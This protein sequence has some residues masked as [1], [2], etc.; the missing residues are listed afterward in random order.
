MA[1]KSRTKRRSKHVRRIRNK[2]HKSHKYSKGKV[3]KNWAMKKMV[4]DP[5]RA[6]GPLL[7]RSA[8]K[9]GDAA[10]A[11]ALYM[12]H[13]LKEYGNDWWNQSAARGIVK[14]YDPK[15]AKILG[16]QKTIKKGKKAPVIKKVMETDVAVRKRL[17]VPS[18]IEARV[19]PN[20]VKSTYV[21]IK[22]A[23][24]DYLNIINRC[25]DYIFTYKA[26]ALTM[27]SEKVVF[28]IDQSSTP[29]R[30]TM[31]IR[32]ALNV[33][34][35]KLEKLRNPRFDQ[36][37]EKSHDIVKILLEKSIELRGGLIEEPVIISWLAS[38]P[39]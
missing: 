22:R 5:L 19:G 15:Y 28:H 16:P 11:S 2:S 14:Q 4:V 29:F 6:S 25:D 18:G 20:N 1:K 33:S 23:F 10:S 35:N 39:N 17:Q 31:K 13:Q 7:K 24:K 27:L 37:K 9:L 26:P 36:I 30:K 8:K 32:D 3:A 38:I 21:R 34:L 12:G